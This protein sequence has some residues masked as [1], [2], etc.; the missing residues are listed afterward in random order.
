MAYSILR[1]VGVEV[2]KMDY[3]GPFMEGMTVQE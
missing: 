1:S 2:G 3:I